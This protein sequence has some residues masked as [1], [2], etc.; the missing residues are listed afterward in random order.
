[1]H[2]TPVATSTPQRS[3]PVTKYQQKK[4]PIMIHIIKMRLFQ[5]NMTDLVTQS[6]HNFS[7]IVESITE[8]FF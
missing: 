3:S 1:M 4:C 5:R 6:H 2:T 8:I 7:E